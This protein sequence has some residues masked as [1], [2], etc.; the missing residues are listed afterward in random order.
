MAGTLNDLG[1]LVRGIATL[2]FVGLL[3]FGGFVGYRAYHR[4]FELEEDLKQS[5]E[6]L[7]ESEAKIGSLE[8]DI[9]LKDKQIDE[10]DMAV[11]LLKVDH[12][13][14]HIKVIDQTKND[15][16]EVRTTLEFVEVND[17]GEPLDSPRRTTIDGDVV[18]IDAWVVKYDD[19]LVETGDP[20]RSASICLFRRLFSETQKPVE[21]FQLDKV[22]AEPVVYRHGEQVNKDEQQI[23]AKFWEYANNPALA[24]KAGVR[25]AHGEAPSIKLVPGKLYKVELRASGGLSVVTEDLPT[26]RAAL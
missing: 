11:R 4:H 6:K 23:W 21:G 22:G 20:L 2:G 9:V 10:L 18:Y 19:K 13:L 25:A 12:R 24:K 5:V 15:D 26:E 16:G 1:N 8:A 7:K 14:A 3:G 17:A